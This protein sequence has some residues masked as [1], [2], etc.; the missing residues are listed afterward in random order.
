MPNSSALLAIQALS[1]ALYVKYGIFMYFMSIIVHTAHIHTNCGCC[2][3]GIYAAYF[4]CEIF[5]IDLPIEHISPTHT[6]TKSMA[7]SVFVVIS[8]RI[9]VSTTCRNSSVEPSVNLCERRQVCSWLDAMHFVWI[10][11]RLAF[12]FRLLAR[13]LVWLYYL[14]LIVVDTVKQH[15]N[16]QTIQQQRPSS[17]PKSTAIGPCV[18]LR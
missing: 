14:V 10:R 15:I 1:S 17:P 8:S 6:H 5:S 2:L 4:I 16:N 13:A 3:L 7:L 12:K 11:Y 9:G 18:A